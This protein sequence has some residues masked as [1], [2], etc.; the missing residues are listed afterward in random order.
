MGTIVRTETGRLA[1]SRIGRAGKTVGASGVPGSK[2]VERCPVCARIIQHRA[3][4]R[5]WKWYCSVECASAGVHIPGL[6]VG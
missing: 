4:V 2:P 3:V 5:A 6:F 1:A